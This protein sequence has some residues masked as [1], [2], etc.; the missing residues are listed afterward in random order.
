MKMNWVLATGH[1]VGASKN[2]AMAK[3]LCYNNQ[4]T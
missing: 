2:A 1:V 3:I 4:R